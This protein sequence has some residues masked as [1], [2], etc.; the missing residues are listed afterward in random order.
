MRSAVEGRLRRIRAAIALAAGGLATT[1]PAAAPQALLPDTLDITRAVQIAMRESPVLRSSQTQADAAAADRLAAWGAFLPT[2]GGTASLSRSSFSRT[3]FVGEEGLSETLPQ[4]LTSSQQGASQRLGVNWTVLDGGRRFAALSQSA[5]NLRAAQRRYDDQQRSVIVTVRRQFLEALRGQELLELT[6]AQIADRELELDIARR[7]YAIAAVERTDVL[8]A[9]SELLVAQTSLLAEQN[10]LQTGLRQLVVSMGL[11]PEAGEGLVLTGEQGMPEG[12]SDIELIVRAAV[13]SDPELSALEAERSA[14]S[15]ALWAARMNYLPTITVGLGWAR[16]ENFGPEE[17]FWQLGRL[18]D[19]SH[20][21][22]VTASWN[23]FDGFDR[24]RQNAQA[25]AAGRRAEEELRRR[26]IE[27]EADVRRYAAEIQQLAQT[28]DLLQRASAISRERLEM[29]Q[30][31]YRLG[32]AS[33]I[34]LQQATSSA[35]NTETSLIQRQ[36]DYLIA[37]SNLAEYVEGRP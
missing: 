1:A 18:G 11:P 16:N 14:A 23:L 15:A 36:Y 13:T 4:T 29:Q 28:L 8:G 22:S 35:Q 19:S 26:R 12:G 33:F 32:T 3:T 20:G 5:A 7:R 25:S 2:A 34:E 17:S 21:F 10:L 24:E 6:R 9:E 37:W 31:R 30:E 27:L